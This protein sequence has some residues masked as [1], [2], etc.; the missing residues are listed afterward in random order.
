[1]AFIVSMVKEIIKTAN[2]SK[3]QKKGCFRIPFSIF[4]IYLIPF[5][6]FKLGIRNTGPTCLGSPEFHV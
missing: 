5:C 3:N 2:S 4:S 6:I 1:M